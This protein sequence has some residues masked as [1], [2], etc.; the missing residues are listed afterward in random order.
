MK[1]ILI[2]C[3]GR[4]GST[5]LQRIISTL[6]N[7]NI[8]GEKAGAISHILKSYKSLKITTSHHIKNKKNPAWYNTFDIEQVKQN[9]KR[10]ILSIL[11]Y[12]EGNKIVGFKDINYYN[13]NN[14]YILD[15]FLKLFPNTKIICHIRDPLSQSKSGWWKNKPNSLNKLEKSNEYLKQYAKQN[16][17][18]YLSHFE[19]L[20]KIE[21]IKKLGEFLGETFNEKEYYDII[22]NNLG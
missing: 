21:E 7:S 3:T 14:I 2:V 12:K 1:F 10:L 17:N 11:D 5:T 15:E 20:F 18:C 19:H 22:N 13:Q 9:I 4:S 6:P 8:T 16:T